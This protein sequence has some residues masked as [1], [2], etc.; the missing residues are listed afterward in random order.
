MT[1][2]WPERTVAD[3]TLDRLA[4]VWVTHGRSARGSFRKDGGPPRGRFAL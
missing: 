4:V 1:Q 3:A 2:W